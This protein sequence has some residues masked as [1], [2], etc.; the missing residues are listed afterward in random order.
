MTNQHTTCAGI[1]YTD[2]PVTEDEARSIL[3]E[4]FANADVD[5]KRLIV[6]IPDGTRSGP[7]DLFFRLFHELLWERV[8]AF[9]YLIALGTHMPMSEEA[10]HQRIGVTAEEMAEGGRYAGVNVFNHEWDKAET[11]RTLGQIPASDIEALTEGRFSQTVDVTVNKLIFD[12]DMVLI[13]GPVF[14]HEV[15]GIS[16]GNKYF[17]PG[18]SGPEVIN[19]THW[20]GALI[21][22]YD[23]IGTKHTP[24]RA[25]INKAAS[26]IDMPK[27]ACCFA[28]KGKTLHGVYAGTIEDSW[29]AAADIAVQ[30][31]I[32]YVDKPYKKVL[33]IMPELYDDIWTAAKGMYKMEPVIADGGEVIIY[34]PHISEFSYTHGEELAAIGYHVRDYFV[35]QWDQFKEMSWSAL[36][37]STHL[38][39]QGR[40]EDGVETPRI[41]VTLATQISPERC[42]QL[43]LGYCDPA[44]IDIAEWENREDEGILMVPRAGE[45]LYRIA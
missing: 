7:V 14:P 37:H 18:I 13:C 34:A 40:F 32:N 2:Q 19:F 25:V 44:T 28:M 1:G 45:M 5:G 36:A 8:D 12:Y 11:F 10:I 43:N 24:V 38:R 35:K 39:G 26:M 22:S 27:M 42:A 16:G 30:I 4:A 31:N 33:S 15:V 6:I 41:D 20:L 3:T 9:D 29:E 23:I 17:F 21:T